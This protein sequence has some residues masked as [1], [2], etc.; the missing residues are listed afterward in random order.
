MSVMSQLTAQCSFMFW[1]VMFVKE[2]TLYFDYCVSQNVTICHDQPTS[3]AST[4]LFLL[5]DYNDSLHVSVSTF[6]ILYGYFIL[7]HLLDLHNVLPLY[8]IYIQ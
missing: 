5:E 6:L 8:I 4:W 2:F 7:Q 3:K 1:G